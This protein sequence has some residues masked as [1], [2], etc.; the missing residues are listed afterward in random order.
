MLLY[1][2]ITTALFNFSIN[3]E[4]DMNLYST[5]LTS[6]LLLVGTKGF[7]LLLECL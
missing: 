4:F 2:K 6:G 7:T 3:T 1:S 5:S